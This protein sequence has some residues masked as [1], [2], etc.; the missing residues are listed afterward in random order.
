MVRSSNGTRHGTRRKMKKGLRDKFK[1]GRFIQ[2]FKPGDKVIIDIDPS[3]HSGMPFRKYKGSM[4]VVR[5]RKGRSY[6][7]GVR[8]GK[9]FMKIEAGAEH[10]KRV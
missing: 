9:K 2:A 5:A 4:G 6:V 10:I 1:P 8:V 3:S 7:L